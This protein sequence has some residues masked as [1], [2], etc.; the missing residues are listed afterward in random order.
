MLHGLISYAIVLNIG[1]QMLVPGVRIPLF[2][3]FAAFV[4][5]ANSEPAQV[6]S[7]AETASMAFSV[8][9]GGQALVTCDL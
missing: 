8:Q 1:S 5:F 2:A 3:A 4:A 7:D 6:D 9:H